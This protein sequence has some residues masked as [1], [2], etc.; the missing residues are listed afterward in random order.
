MCGGGGSAP[1]PASQTVH[2]DTSNIPDSFLPYYKNLFDKG[3]QVTGEGYDQYGQQRLEGFSPEQNQAF[4]GIQGMQGQ[5]QP[6]INNANTLA[7]QAGQSFPNA[8]MA[9]YTNPWQQNVTDTALREAQRTGDVT[10]SQIGLNMTQAAGGFGGDRQSILQAENNRNTAQLM[11]DIQYKGSA[12]AF[13]QGANLFNADRTA[14]LNASGAF[15]NIAGQQQ[16]LGLNANN[17]LSTVGQQKQAS[18]QSA[19]DIS[20][21][22]FINQRD[23]P[24][25][26]AQRM[27]GLLHGFDT[28]K[29]GYET[30][31]TT[32]PSPSIT[33]MLGGLG[34]AGLGM[35]KA[36]GYKVGGPVRAKYAAGGRVNF[37]D[38]GLKDISPTD[39]AKAL[40]I[41]EDEAADLIRRRYVTQEQIPEEPASP[42]ADAIADWYKRNVKEGNAITSKW[43]S[44]GSSDAA[45][46]EGKSY[47]A[48]TQGSGPYKAPSGL[49]ALAPPSA[50]PALSG[51]RGV[52][53]DSED[54]SQ[55]RRERNWLPLAQAG[56]SMLSSKSPT[57]AGALGEAGTAGIKSRGEYNKSYQ[58]MVG[59]LSTKKYREAM[60]GYYGKMGDIA[61]RQKVNQILPGSDGNTMLVYESGQTAPLMD[62]GQPIK[63]ETLRNLKDKLSPQEFQLKL[64][65]VLVK[66]HPEGISNLKPGQLDTE[67]AELQRLSGSNGK[68]Q[69]STVTWDAAAGKYRIVK[70]E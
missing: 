47:P 18:G 68:Q 42:T 16:Q 60:S 8:N 25:T 62:N 2:S 17:A 41:S 55:L 4:A 69:A 48:N 31:Q 11:G 6:D 66:N 20:Y 56:F 22:D 49:T 14:A 64:L 65:D 19:L 46:T 54:L 53:Q 28:G 39:L 10:N 70:P 51:N 50:P 44:D 15:S 30:T 63:Y 34:T 24:Y 61:G 3:E 35:Y 45:P 52:D 13:T 27:S 26:Q 57:F 59:E 36:F 23:Y 37:A 43:G 7:G 21:Q 58:D 38:G 9:A 5:F 12:D 33:Q 32:Q 29:T 1:A 40:N 67:M